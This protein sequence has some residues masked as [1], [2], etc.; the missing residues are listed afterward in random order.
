MM[1]MMDIKYEIYFIN[2][3]WDNKSIG[4]IIKRHFKLLKIN[5]TNKKKTLFKKK[6][7]TK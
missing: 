6:I 4:G 7:K 3:L 2:K 1:N 5:L